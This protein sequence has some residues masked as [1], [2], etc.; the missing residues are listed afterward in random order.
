MLFST[1]LTRN[2]IVIA[3]KK[4][5]KKLCMDLLTYSTFVNRISFIYCDENMYSNFF[6]KNAY[7]QKSNRKSNK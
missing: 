4:Y 1:M 3:L 2:A 6:L 5:V 7:F